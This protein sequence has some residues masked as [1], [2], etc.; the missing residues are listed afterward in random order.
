MIK[1]LLVIIC[2][3]FLTSC[4][5]VQNIENKEKKSL[6]KEFIISSETRLKTNK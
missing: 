1:C 4:Q 6:N 2:Y 5:S 3:L